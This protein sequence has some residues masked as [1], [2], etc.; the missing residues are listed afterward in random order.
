MKKLL[1]LLLF[2][3]LAFAQDSVAPPPTADPLII[4]F[5]NRCKSAI[6]WSATLI[7]AKHKGTTEEDVFK[8]IYHDY[9]HGP[10]KGRH[11]DTISYMLA[12][13][14]SIYSAENLTD[15]NNYVNLLKNVEQSCIDFIEAGKPESTTNKHPA[16]ST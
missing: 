15:I 10:L 8:Q 11:P 12:I 2:P 1:V 13:V 9:A 4:E 3:I 5:D 7:E 14:S 6:V 16:L